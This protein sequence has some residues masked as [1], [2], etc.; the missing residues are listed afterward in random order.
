MYTDGLSVVHHPDVS[1]R[2]ESEDVDREEEFDGAILE[3]LSVNRET[4][5][6]GYSLA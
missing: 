1:V 2:K 5:A 4:F 6:G 3:G